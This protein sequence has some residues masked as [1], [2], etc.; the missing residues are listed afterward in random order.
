MEEGGIKH[1]ADFQTLSGLVIEFQNS[2]ISAS[3][4]ASKNSFIKGVKIPSFPNK[5]SPDLIREIADFWKLS[6]SNFSLLH[7]VA[8]ELAHG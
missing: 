5:R 1:V 3:R 8:S 6:K 2:S 4:E 7:V